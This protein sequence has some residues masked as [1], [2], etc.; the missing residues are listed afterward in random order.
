MKNNPKRIVV[1]CTATPPGRDVSAADIDR[2]HRDNGWAGIGYHK[3]VRLDGSV[4]NG[5]DPDQDGD[6]E[7][8]IG[9]HAYGHNKDTLAIVYVGGVDADFRPLDTRTPVQRESL[10]L[11]V[12][13]WQRKFS[14]PM[15]DV[16][17]HYE[18]DPRKACP[19]FDMEAFRAELRDMHKYGYATVYLPLAQEMDQ[20]VRAIQERLD[21]PVDG[22]P[23]PVTW[24]ALRKA[25]GLSLIV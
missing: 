9:A 3:V 20:R 23:G 16:V 4:E 22:I 21:V 24:A 11:Q 2:W 19:S 8:H 14:I 12:A 17:G 1:H 10:L 13:N 6:V 15:T 7:E 18:L 5:R 25:L